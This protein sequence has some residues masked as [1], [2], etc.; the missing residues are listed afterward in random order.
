MRVCN[1]PSKL[2]SIDDYANRVLA[3]H[4]P[5]VRRHGDIR[6]FPPEPAADWAV[7][8][9][10]GGFP[11]QERLFLVANPC[12]ITRVE[13]RIF[14]GFH[15]V[16]RDE[17]WSS[18]KGVKSG[19]GWKRWLSQAA[20]TVDKAVSASDFS[21]MDDGFSKDLDRIACLGN[22]IV[23]QI[24]EWIGRRLVQLEAIE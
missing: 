23:P 11:C 9:I 16:Q 22:A 6:S 24:A 21:G 17:Q 2:R 13:R 15:D 14:D 10:C 1:A 18:A 4:W 7:D 5:N 20:F 12:E 3:K 19:R 8:V